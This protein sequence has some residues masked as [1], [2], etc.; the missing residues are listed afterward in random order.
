[1]EKLS[2]T[3]NVRL[4]YN[5]RRFLGIRSASELS[6]P[7]MRSRNFDPGGSPRPDAE[8][9]F[10]D[11]FG[12]PPRLAAAKEVPS[13]KP[14][15]HYGNLRE[16]PVFGEESPRR[17]VNKDFFDDIYGGECLPAARKQPEKRVAFYSM[18]GSRILSPTCASPPKTVP[19]SPVPSLP[20]RMSQ[21]SD[22]GKGADNGT[23]ITPTSGSPNIHKLSSAEGVPPSPILSV[24]S[25][26]LQ[27]H[28]HAHSTRFSV[29]SVQGQQNPVNEVRSSYQ[30]S[31]LSHQYS[32]MDNESPKLTES[33]GRRSEGDIRAN[34]IQAGHTS[35]HLQNSNQ[36]HFSIHKWAGKGAA[37]FMPLKRWDGSGQQNTRESKTKEQTTAFQEVS[38]RDVGKAFVASTSNHG[39]FEV[40]VTPSHNSDPNKKEY[41]QQKEKKLSD[42]DHYNAFGQN[43]PKSVENIGPHLKEA[44]EF[45]VKNIPSLLKND[46]EE[47][48]ME[49]TVNQQ[50]GMGQN[51]TKSRNICGSQN[52]KQAATGYAYED[53]EAANPTVDTVEPNPESRLHGNRVKSKVKE[54]IKIFSQ[55]A[56][57]KSIT[58]ADNRAE[59]SGRK[60][61]QP[62][63]VE[64]KLNASHLDTKL[65]KNVSTSDDA[66]SGRTLKIHH[67]LEQEED[68]DLQFDKPDIH[69]SSSKRYEF[70]AQETSKVAH[71]LKGRSPGD[72]L[73]GNCL[74]EPS[75]SDPKH[76]IL[77]P[78]P[79][80][81]LQNLDAKIRKWADGKE[82]NIRSLLS[83][84]Q[85]ILWPGSGW[86]PVP[87]VDIIEGS[88]VKRTY[89][90]ALLC[91]HPD[92][93]QQKDATVHQ[94]YIAEK[95]FDIVQ[96]AWTH[97]NDIS[98]FS[99][100]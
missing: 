15:E 26:K 52:I 95:V 47:S 30:R 36:F 88:A 54:F 25:P 4:G 44:S 97:F 85:Y 68:F 51:E 78:Q 73:P 37:L 64:A 18:P 39:C 32:F 6:S 98:S 61:K 50:A 13:P 3:E 91:L 20:S 46:S 62:S 10:G 34:V 27:P 63:N 7:I 93:L 1:M 11:V 8:F 5:S 19:L 87:L 42:S 72:N 48:G 45:Q 57:Q 77:T 92:K 76:E 58:K 75:S 90:K 71:D 69:S 29:H 53:A 35:K 65:E 100:S 23:S 89:Q 33:S 99:S 21:F 24:S 80:E 84:L 83:T 82:G 79:Q 59:K 38:T 56:S 66:A 43:L 60:G 96:E 94:K 14:V 41:Q 81:E 70:T 74:V 16:K 55:E 22:L 86:K 49:R 40:D 12:G 9:D 67:I 2:C 31:R 28:G 17:R